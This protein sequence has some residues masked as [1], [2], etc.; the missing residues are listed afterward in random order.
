MKIT[1]D[2]TLAE[3]QLALAALNLRLSVELSGTDDRFHVTLAG[4]KLIMQA[5]APYLHDAVAVAMASYEDQYAKIL[6]MG[7]MS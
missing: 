3:L 7:G 1:S 4:N 5:A 6:A 2:T